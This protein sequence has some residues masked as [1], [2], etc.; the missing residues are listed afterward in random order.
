MNKRKAILISFISAL[1]GLLFGFDTAVISGTIRMVS[2]EFVLGVDL[3]GWFVSSAILGCVIGVVL[4]GTISD[5]IGRK[6]VL[7]ASAIFFIVSAT[8]CALANSMT[9]LIVFR[10]IGGTGIG[11]A[12][13]ISPM[14]IAELSPTKLRGRLVALYQLAITIGILSQM[15]L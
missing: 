10:L 3:E 9:S 2:N 11:F 12:S 15:Q 4:A 8:G 6:K 5:I 7:I 1:G 13:I 14:Y